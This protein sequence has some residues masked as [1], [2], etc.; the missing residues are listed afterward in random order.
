MFSAEALFLYLVKSIRYL[1]KQK[2]RMFEHFFV[3]IF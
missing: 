3:N 1:F 2:S